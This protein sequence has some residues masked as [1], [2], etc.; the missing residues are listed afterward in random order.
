[1]ESNKQAQ[2]IFN[3]SKHGYKGGVTNN[4][5][6]IPVYSTENTQLIFPMSS[7]VSFFL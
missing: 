1:M 7:I 2:I 4:H 6:M 5:K 3:F